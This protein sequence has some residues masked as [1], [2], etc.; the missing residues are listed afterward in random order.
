MLLMTPQEVYLQLPRLHQEI[1]AARGVSET[2][3]IITVD[4]VMQRLRADGRSV[5]HPI[6]E[7]AFAISRAVGDYLR[8]NVRVDEDGN[9]YLTMTLDEAA[10]FDDAG[11][12]TEAE[13]KPGLRFGRAKAVD[14]NAGISR[15]R[16]GGEVE[17]TKTFSFHGRYHH[18]WHKHHDLPA[19]HPIHTEKHGTFLPSEFKKEGKPSSASGKKDKDNEDKST[20]LVARRVVGGVKAGTQGK[21]IKHGKLT[22]VHFGDAGEKHFTEDQAAQLL[23][24][25]K[26]KGTATSR[27][28]IG[29]HQQIFH[30]GDMPKTHPL[31]GKSVE[32]RVPWVIHKGARYTLARGARTATG[33]R[34]KDSDSYLT[35][36]GAM[37]GK[38]GLH[39]DRISK[40]TLRRNWNPVNIPVPSQYERNFEPVVHQKGR[41]RGKRLTGGAISGMTKVVPGGIDHPNQKPE[42]RDKVARLAHG[43]SQRYPDWGLGVGTVRSKYD[44]LSDR[45]KEGIHMQIH[46]EIRGLHVPDMRGTDSPEIS[47]PEQSP[48]HE[49]LDVPRKGKGQKSLRRSVQARK[50]VNLIKQVAD[51]DTKTVRSR[52]GVLGVSKSQRASAQKVHRSLKALGMAEQIGDEI[53]RRVMHE[54]EDGGMATLGGPIQQLGEPK[55]DFRNSYLYA[56]RKMEYVSK[57]SKPQVREDDLVAA[58]MRA[59]ETCE[60]LSQEFPAYSPEYIHATMISEADAWL[61]SNFATLTDSQRFASS[62][63]SAL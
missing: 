29:G 53:I 3:G 22:T 36:F 38:H 24:I 37:G 63:R 26:D 61:T 11:L 33:N 32:L 14:S 10:Q 35:D 51:P 6:V 60:K 39:P 50:L 56:K 5:I 8:A 21:L 2:S 28:D 45:Q 25:D 17:A 57:L 15:A 47:S 16:I 23:H 31:A 42:L 12:L 44:T 34:E 20:V 30:L 4:D 18:D 55:G 27:V 41:L 1:C 9:R 40:K 58:F 46:R 19:D 54:F 43:L 62:L 52:D 49:P 59:S 13:K 7:E 48:K